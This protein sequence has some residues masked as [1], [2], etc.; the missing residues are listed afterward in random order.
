M[1]IQSTLK[2]ETQQ[3]DQRNSLNI[4]FFDDVFFLRNIV[5]KFKIV[6]NADIAEF[7]FLIFTFVNDEHFC[8]IHRTQELNESYEIILFKQFEFAF[9]SEFHD[10]LKY[11]QFIFVWI[12]FFNSSSSNF[13]WL[14]QRKNFSFEKR[15]FFFVFDWFFKKNDLIE[16]S[17]WVNQD[18]FRFN[19]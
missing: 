1:S 11:S 15:F 18:S 14:R 4:F 10:W 3:I 8:W 2:W 6:R 12:L 7:H 19:D 17:F 5:I 13:C 9:L 16:R